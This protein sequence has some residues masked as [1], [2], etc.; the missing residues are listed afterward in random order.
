ML[1][2]EFQKAKCLSPNHF[3]FAYK[4]Q[5]LSFI[6]LYTFKITPFLQTVSLYIMTSNPC[7]F[8]RTRPGEATIY[9]FFEKILTKINALKA[10]IHSLP[11][12][13][14]ANTELLKVHSPSC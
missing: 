8:S 13:V 9:D 6:T 4:Y 14:T 10:Q 3:S 2:L 7:Q 5:M 1:I 12:A 11:E